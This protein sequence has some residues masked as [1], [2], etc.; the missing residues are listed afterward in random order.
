MED[1]KDF[2]DA[3]IAVCAVNATLKTE[4]VFGMASGMY[5]TLSK[6]ILGIESVARGTK[7]SRSGDETRI[8]V[9]I[10][11]DYGSNI[12]SVAWEIQ[13]NVRKEIKT[14]VDIDISAVNIHVQGVEIPE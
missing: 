9:S 4:G 12:P 13:E 5:D 14:M 6:N 10:I 7:V 1:K 2:S 8:D 11:A 3:I